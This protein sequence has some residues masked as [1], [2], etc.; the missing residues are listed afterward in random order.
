MWLSI[1]DSFHTWAKRYSHV[2]KKIL[3][4]TNM[5]M[6]L[7][8]KALLNIQAMAISK[9][10]RYPNV[11]KNMCTFR[12]TDG[13]VLTLPEPYRHFIKE[14][15]GMLDFCNWKY[16]TSR[17]LKS[18]ASTDSPD[19]TLL[20][21]EIHQRKV[22]QVPFSAYANAEPP[23]QVVSKAKRRAIITEDEGRPFFAC[24]PAGNRL[25]RRRLLT[26]FSVE[27]MLLKP[28]VERVRRKGRGKAKA[29]QSLLIHYPRPPNHDLSSTPQAMGGME[30]PTGINQTPEDEVIIIT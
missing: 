24:S 12:R 30:L 25:K 7:F 16:G 13:E 17:M 28:E 19:P 11:D 27:G 6:M 15:A 18:I 20:F 2:N 3:R 22:L 23:F 29:S 14:E 5:R 8:R 1:N 4:I 21:M 10:L 9:F 26:D